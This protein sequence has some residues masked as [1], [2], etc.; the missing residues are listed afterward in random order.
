MKTATTIL[1]HLTSRPQFKKLKQ[2]EC[3]KKYIQIL[4]PKWQK[5]V[6]FIYIKDSTLFIAIK[7]PGF[8]QE[9]NYNHD[10]LKDLLKQINTYV[11]PCKEMTASKV[12]VFHS[13]Y[14]PM[15]QEKTPYESVPHY[16][17]R[18]YGEFELPQ[19]EELKEAFIKIQ[20]VI[21]CNS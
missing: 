1:S 15:E 20:D 19:Q 13:K 18:A 16:K 8:K 2:Q 7:H 17:E 11:E 12:V 6:A 9:L 10:L 5:A 4:R 14:H 21:V 3:Y